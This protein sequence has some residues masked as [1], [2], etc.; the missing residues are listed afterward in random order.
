M[1]KIKCS[2]CGNEIELSEALK[3]EI[4][5]SLIIELDKKHSEE[6]EAVK[7]KAS[8]DAGIKL[9]EQLKLLK[10]QSEAD[11][12][13]KTEMREQMKG[14]FDQIRKLT[15]DKNDAEINAEKKLFEKE[16]KIKE[17][18]EKSADEKQRLNIAARDKTITDLK[19]ALDEAQRKASQ[20]S[21]QLQGEIMELD[22]EDLFA[23]S[24]RD[25]DLEPVAKGVKGGDIRHTVKSPRG[26]ACGVILWEVKRTKG[27]TDSWA[28]KLKND[29]RAE[30]ANIPIII[31][32]VLPKTISED[33]G[34]FDGVWVCRPKMAVILGTLLRKSLLDAGLQKALAE[35]RGTKAD[36]LYTF[37]TS[38]EFV[39]QVEAMIETYRDMTQQVGKE[40][41]AYEKF[42]SE[43]EK[44]AQKLL[45]ST[46]NIIGSMQGHIGQSSM[47]RIKGL[48]LLASGEEDEIAN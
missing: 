43:R 30:K 35:N 25:D 2:K 41:V 15:K 11:K 19:K 46:A 27:W 23:N 14:L 45:L 8:E 37:V 47:P 20:G 38:H 40:R 24:F 5:S 33:I 12:Q 13:E 31:T 36:A 6:I 44:Q 48:D 42:W 28:T 1:T 18:A 21:Q 10:E 29:L 22:F 26:T 17:D 4:K 34:T 3:D 16:A 7:K 9:G 39:Q 32:E